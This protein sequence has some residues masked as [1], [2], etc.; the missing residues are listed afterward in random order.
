MLPA[1]NVKKPV[2]LRVGYLHVQSRDSS[3]HEQSAMT[4]CIYGAM[5]Y[6]G[7]SLYCIHFNRIVTRNSSHN[8]Q[9]NLLPLIINLIVNIPITLT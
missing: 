8:F 1:R 7:F 9:I 2:W 4:V 5:L 3:F 6:Y